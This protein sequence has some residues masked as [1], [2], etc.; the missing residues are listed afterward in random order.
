[1]TPLNRACVAVLNHAI[2]QCRLAHRHGEMSP[3]QTEDLME[4]IHNLPPTLMQPYYM[5]AHDAR[6]RLEAY[7]KKW[8]CELPHEM[9]CAVF[10]AAMKG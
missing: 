6:W 5:T 1:M 4:A 7:D 10:D 3:E 8:P 9:L 2:L